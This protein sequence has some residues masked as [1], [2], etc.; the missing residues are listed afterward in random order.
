MI[1][2]VC[3]CPYRVIVGVDDV[4]G[5]VVAEWGIGCVDVGVVCGGVGVVCGDP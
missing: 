1:M 3:I 5:V 4:C 2:C